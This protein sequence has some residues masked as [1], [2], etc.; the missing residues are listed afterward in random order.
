MKRSS[1]VKDLIKSLD[2]VYEI[3][4][5]KAYI[6]GMIMGLATVI[7]AECDQPK[8]IPDPLWSRLLKASKED[9]DF[10]KKKENITTRQTHPKSIR[11]VLGDYIEEE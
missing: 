4:P 6:R 3:H 2:D 8:C 7:Y 11:D 10:R 5:N 1:E 9:Y